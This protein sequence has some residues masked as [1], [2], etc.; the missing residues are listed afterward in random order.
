VDGGEGDFVTPT[1]STRD[2]KAQLEREQI[3]LIV[4]TIET[5]CQMLLALIK[6]I[7]GLR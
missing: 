3:D 4:K 1:T 5:V 6:T 7:K 2:K